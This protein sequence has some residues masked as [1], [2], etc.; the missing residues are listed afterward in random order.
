[1]VAYLGKLVKRCG[2]RNGH[3]SCRAPGPYD[4]MASDISRCFFAQLPDESP[5]SCKAFTLWRE[6]GREY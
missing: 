1:M 6:R 3:C 5:Y 4:H 2:F